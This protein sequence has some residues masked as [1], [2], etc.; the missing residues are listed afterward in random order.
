[1][2]LVKIMRT[3]IRQLKIIFITITQGLRIL[4]HMVFSDF[5][6]N[7]KKIIQYTHQARM[8]HFSMELEQQEISSKKLKYFLLR[9]FLFLGNY[10]FE[11]RVRKKVKKVKSYYEL[12]GKAFDLLIRFDTD[13]MFISSPLFSHKRGLEEGVRVLRNTILEETEKRGF[14]VFN[15]LPFLNRNLEGIREMETKTKFDIFYKSIIEHRLVSRIL[16]N[17]GWEHSGGC[18]AEKVFAE[19]AKKEIIFIK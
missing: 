16:M 18:R 5:V 4:F 12:K 9:R 3:K 7:F 13:T 19:Q 17:H 15:Q 1:M 6:I 10:I 2:G 8:E 11:Y 14:L